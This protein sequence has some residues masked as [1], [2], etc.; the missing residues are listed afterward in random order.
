MSL[1]TAD[2]LQVSCLI[3]VYNGERYLQEA[4]DSVCV[5]TT[6]VFEIVVVDD[7]STDR[8]AEIVARQGD[9]VRYVYQEHA[10]EAA[11]RNNAVEHAR[12][13]IIAFQD[14]DDLWR[15]QKVER[16][17]ARLAA[18]PDL[19]VCSAHL[20]NFWIPELQ[21]EAAYYAGHMLSRPQGGYGH[22][23]AMLIR[24]T[25]FDRVGRF[26]ESLPLGVDTEWFIRATEA[27]A[28]MELLPDV[29][30]D[31]R[32]HTRNISRGLHPSLPEIIKQSMDRRRHAP[33]GVVTPLPAF[34]APAPTPEGGRHDD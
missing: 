15:P 34:F 3:P 7:G 12:G 10:G 4:L 20:Q 29:L 2:G 28:R 24:R 22:L 14:A 23:Y 26:D 25:L 16:Q 30:V 27:G 1:M 19:D 21:D 11:A 6:P 5:Q 32:F 9:R 13:A 18:R 8:T 33:H 31:R 17:L